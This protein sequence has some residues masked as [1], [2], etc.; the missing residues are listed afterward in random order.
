ML[1][2]SKAPFFKQM[3][4]KFRHN[5]PKTLKVGSLVVLSLDVDD[6]Q[7]ILSDNSTMMITIPSASVVL[8]LKRTVL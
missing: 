3:N 1:E 4:F 7:V 5:K 2:Y 8:L 6:I